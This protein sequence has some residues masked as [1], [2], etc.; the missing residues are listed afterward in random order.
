MSDNQQLALEY[1]I[2]YLKAFYGRGNTY[3]KLDQHYRSQMLGVADDDFDWRPYLNNASEDFICFDTVKRYCAHQIRMGKDLPDKLRYWIADVMEGIEPTINEPQGG[4]ETGAIVNAFLPRLV[5]ILVDKFD[6]PATRGSGSDPIS[7][8]DVV[9]KA[10]NSV[11]E[12]LE[13]RKRGFESIR[14]S[15]ARAKRNGA[16]KKL[17]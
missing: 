9:E 5:Q 14:K 13:I 15:Y 8:C 12:A 7:A 16:F 11:P 3:K 1:A 4:V 2:D 10:I 6:L 17:F